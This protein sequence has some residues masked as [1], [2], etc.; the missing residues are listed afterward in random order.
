MFRFGGI[1][2]IIGCFSRK[3]Q[4]NKVS[5]SEAVFEGFFLC[6]LGGGVK[7]FLFSPVLGEMIQFDQYIFQMG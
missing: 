3:K 1:Q 4:Q 2:L 6:S 5:L 7:H